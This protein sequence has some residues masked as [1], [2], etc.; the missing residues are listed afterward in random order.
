MTTFSFET[1]GQWFTSGGSAVVREG[2]RRIATVELRPGSLVDG[3]SWTWVGAFGPEWTLDAERGDSRNGV[4]RADCERIGTLERA[5][6][7]SRMTATA[8]DDGEVVLE[9]ESPPMLSREQVVRLPDGGEGVIRREGG[10]LLLSTR[11]EWSLT[12]PEGV[13]EP[14]RTL[15]LAAVLAVDH[16]RRRQDS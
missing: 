15:A 13:G 10:M 16:R 2:D 7:S 12:V 11:E 8:A 6:A 5:F 4:V 3:P 9:V 14:S 1:R